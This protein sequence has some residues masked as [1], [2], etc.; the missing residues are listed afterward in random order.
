MTEGDVR[1]PQP[2]G[3][4]AYHRFDS[5]GITRSL[6][7][8]GACVGLG[9]P[10]ILLG[11]LSIFFHVPLWG[12]VTCLLLGGA[13]VASGLFM[14]F[15]TVPRLLSVD[16]GL[17]VQKDGLLIERKNEQR[18][19]S[20]GEIARVTCENECVVLHLK[21]GAPYVVS[22]AF[23]R[24]TPVEV[25]RTLERTRMRIALAMV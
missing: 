4:L 11:S 1:D 10:T 25:A 23:A 5:P 7:R 8:A 3:L 6:L 22:D 24:S 9:G 19:F 15:V 21:D 17:S 12:R 13:A 14:G 2:V 20:W 16:C 18:F